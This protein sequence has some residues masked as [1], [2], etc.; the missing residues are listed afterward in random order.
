[1][2]HCHEKSENTEFRK[3]VQNELKMIRYLNLRL[4]IGGIQNV[5]LP[6]LCLRRDHRVEIPNS[7]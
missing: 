5:V 3:Y 6:K 4:R 7:R 1:M 2:H